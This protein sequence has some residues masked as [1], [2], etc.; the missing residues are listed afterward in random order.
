MSAQIQRLPSGRHIVSLL[1]DPGPLPEPSPAETLARKA[2]WSEQVALRRRR[3]KD[4]P[5]LDALEAECLA[6]SL[7]ISQ[8]R[9]IEE[10]DAA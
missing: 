9:A 6:L 7:A 4:A 1:G 8:W 10:E 5:D 3:I 2:Y